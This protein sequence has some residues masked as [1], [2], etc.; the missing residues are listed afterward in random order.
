M[1]R[2]YSKLACFRLARPDAD[3]GMFWTSAN[4]RGQVAGNSKADD[5][6]KRKLEDLTLKHMDSIR[7][8]KP[9]AECAVCRTSC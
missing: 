3:A 5:A 4:V 2:E 7:S 8:G 9:A 1:F 6:R